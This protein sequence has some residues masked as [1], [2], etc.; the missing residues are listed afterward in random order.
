MNEHRIVC[1]LSH[2]VC[3]HSPMFVQQMRW[4]CASSISSIF[5][6]CTWYTMTTYHRLNKVISQ[7]SKKY[8]I[9]CVNSHAC[10][11]RKP[12]P[13]AVLMQ[14]C[15]IVQYNSSLTIIMRMTY[16]NQAQFYVSSTR[17]HR[18]MIEKVTI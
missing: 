1:L 2:R 10:I 17:L 5:D 14:L 12:I 9:N 7:S 13:Y 6:S 18:L 16:S 15:E 8:I 4:V 11:R 3:P